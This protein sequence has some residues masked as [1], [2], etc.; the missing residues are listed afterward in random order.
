MSEGAKYRR[1]WR[2]LSGSLPR[3][4]T[5]HTLLPGPEHRLPVPAEPRGTATSPVNA[6]FFPRCTFVTAARAQGKQ[7]RQQSQSCA[8]LGV[9]GRP[10]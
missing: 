4:G 10:M 2:C 7:L 1:R 3:A 5:L 8:E 6:T 9:G